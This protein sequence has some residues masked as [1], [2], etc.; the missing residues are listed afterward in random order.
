MDA[1]ILTAELESLRAEVIRLRAWVGVCRRGP[2]IVALAHA[3]ALSMIEAHYTQMG[4]GRVEMK[5]QG[6]SKRRWAWAVAYLRYARVVSR[7]TGNWRYGLVW[8]ARAEDAVRLVADA[9]QVTLAQLRALKRE[10]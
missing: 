9:Q 6:M 3:D 8:L 2:G 1:K 7:H 5:R 10:V 4:T